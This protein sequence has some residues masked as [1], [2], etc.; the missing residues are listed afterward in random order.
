MNNLGPRRSER[1]AGQVQTLA[2]L[3]SKS[4]WIWLLSALIVV[5]MSSWLAFLD[6]GLDRRLAGCR[7]LL[8]AFF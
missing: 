7:R 6:W 1:Y 3:V 5:V 2:S 8:A 4:V